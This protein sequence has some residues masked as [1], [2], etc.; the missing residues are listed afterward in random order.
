MSD[1][2]RSIEIVKR[3]WAENPYYENAEKWTRIF[4]EASSDFR[5]AFDLLDVTHCIELAC[6]HGRHAEQLMLAKG[7]AVQSLYCLDVVEK[8]I[9][10]TSQRLAAYPQ[11]QCNLIDGKDFG[12]IPNRTITA[13]YCYDAMVHFSEDIIGSYLVDAHRVLKPGGRVL[14]H[15]SNLDAPQTGRQPGSDWTRN[16]HGRNHMTLTLFTSLAAK[17]GLSILKT[18][19]RQWGT[20]PELDRI[21]LLEKPVR[22]GVARKTSR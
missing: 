15:H 16:P 20:V 22:D 6:G 13:I 21:T 4:W 19:A 1:L 2:A 5:Q 9:E 17:A 3:P 7:H 11:V 10:V 14:L 8:N 18:K 12:P